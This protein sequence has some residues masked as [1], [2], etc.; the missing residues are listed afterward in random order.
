MEAMLAKIW[1]IFLDTAQ[2]ILLAF[3][4]FLVIYVFLVRP[5]QV[6]GKSMFPTFEHGEYVLT[7]LIGLRLGTLSRG[8]I[9]V[10][11]SP[12]SADKDFIKRVIGT[13]EDSVSVKEGKVYI[14]GSMLNESAYL[15]SDVYTDA[16][17]FLREG[18]SV[19]V[20]AGHYFVMGDNRGNS[21]DSRQWGF[22][23]KEKIIGK[24]LFV[25]WPPS[26]ARAIENPYKN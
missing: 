11:E 3:S 4:I 19:T 5:F 2:S 6:D 25:Y 16:G 20:P 26:R 23:E 9:V 21:S 18:E 10:F 8:E 7:N 22:V 15:A 1:E 17:G 13:P 24:S 14:N 12:E